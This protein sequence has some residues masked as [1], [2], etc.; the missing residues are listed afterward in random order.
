MVPVNPLIAYHPPINWKT[1]CGPRGPPAKAPITPRFRGGD[2]R[3]N[4]IAQEQPRLLQW[5]EGNREE[6]REI[7][8]IRVGVE[9]T[10]LA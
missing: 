6:G 2:H 3:I 1:L 9:F 10:D 8:Y 5:L 7:K 4:A